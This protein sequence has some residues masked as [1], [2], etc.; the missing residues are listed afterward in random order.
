MSVS[1]TDENSHHL[2]FVKYLL[3]KLKNND[4]KRIIKITTTNLFGTCRR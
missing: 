1:I 2:F 4:N 3:E